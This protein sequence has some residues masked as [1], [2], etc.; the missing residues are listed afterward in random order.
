MC[1]LYVS[2]T[3][4]RERAST[5]AA[6]D[7]A[8]A[9]GGS[10]DG[11]ASLYGDG[12]VRLWMDG[13]P[14]D[15]E[16]PLPE[17]LFDTVFLWR[18]RRAI[19]DPRPALPPAEQAPQEDGQ[20]ISQAREQEVRAEGSQEGRPQVGETSREI[21]QAGR[22]EIQQEVHRQKERS[23]FGL[24]EA[25]QEGTWQEAVSRWANPGYPIAPGP[26]RS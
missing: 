20:E 17:S 18:L 5:P 25:G 7:A 22:P 23:A 8:Y 15:G 3:G 10:E 6:G 2:F 14:A 16:N 19:A 9:F 21:R 1:K 11:R 24:A 12:L 26:R 13:P 4:R